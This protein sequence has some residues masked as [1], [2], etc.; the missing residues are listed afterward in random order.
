MC[1]VKTRIFNLK[2]LQR[3]EIYTC[4]VYNVHMLS[5]SVL[6]AVITFKFGLETIAKTLQTSLRRSE[7]ALP[8]RNPAVVS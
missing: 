5:F 7:E 1:H 3:E 6:R 8:M 4:Y 2:A